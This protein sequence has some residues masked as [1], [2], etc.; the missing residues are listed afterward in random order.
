MTSTGILYPTELLIAGARDEHTTS[1]VYRCIQL[2][3]RRVA[4]NPAKPSNPI[5]MVPGS[6]TKNP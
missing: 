2:R 6:G 1:P 5:A 3:R 4:P